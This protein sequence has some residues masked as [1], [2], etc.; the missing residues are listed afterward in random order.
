M[1]SLAVTTPVEDARPGTEEFLWKVHANV[2][3]QI[4]FADQKAGLMAVLAT[5]VMGGLHTLK[6]YE[7]FTQ[8]PLLKWGWIGWAS[9]LAFGLLA[10]ALGACFLSVM[11]RRRYTHPKGYIF[12]GAIAAWENGDRYHEAVESA[13]KEEMLRH[14]SHQVYALSSICYAKYNWINR[15]LILVVIGSELG[16]I[17]MLLPTFT[18]S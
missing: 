2:T 11:P 8:V 15:G 6:V 10:C 4:K 18:G 17:L 12:W 14:L 13:S 5:G 3:D 16:G 9:L 7:N 1:G